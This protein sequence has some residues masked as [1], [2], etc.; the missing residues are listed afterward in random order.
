M[1]LTRFD[2]SQMLSSKI[3][4]GALTFLLFVTNYYQYKNNSELKKDFSGYVAQSSELSY[5]VYRSHFDG[6]WLSQCTP[7]ADS[8]ARSVLPRSISTYGIVIVLNRIQCMSC[9]EFHRDHIR[10]LVTT[11]SIPVFAVAAGDYLTLLTKDFL[12]IAVLHLEQMRADAFSNHYPHVILFVDRAGRIV[13]SD[14][15][16]QQHRDV[17]KMFYSILRSFLS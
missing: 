2:S 3:V 11:Y 4:V 6:K 13:C 16:D 10:E 8:I 5:P 7:V 14:I 17:A 9:Y 12:Q 1:T 15:S